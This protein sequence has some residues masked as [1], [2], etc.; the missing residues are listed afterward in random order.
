MFI[1]VR[2]NN[3]AVKIINEPKLYCEDSY[4]NFT[5]IFEQGDYI[6][7]EI[8]DCF[9]KGTLEYIWSDSIEVED[10]DYE[11]LTINIEDIIEVTSLMGL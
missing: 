4:G 1:A 2:N 9:V 3:M 5:G 6:T 8:D 7:V 10:F 11:V